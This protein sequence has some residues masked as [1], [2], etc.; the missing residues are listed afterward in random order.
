V[1]AP[2]RPVSNK[3]VIKGM[4]D[5]FA[6]GDVGVVVGALSGNVVWTEAENHPYADRNPYKGP[7]AVLSGIFARIPAEWDDFQVL[8]ERY[9]E[10][11][12]QVVVEGRYTGRYKANG[13]AIDGQFVHSWTLEGGKV[14][15]FQQYTDTAQWQQVTGPAASAGVNRVVH[16]EIGAQDPERCAKFFG[17][18]FGW[19]IM[20]WEGPQP[21][22]LATTGPMSGVGINGGILRHPD[23]AA[24]TINTIQVDSIENA[25]E[26]VE[27]A[28]GKVAMPKMAIPGVGWLAY[29]HDTEG[30]MFG[31]HVPDPAAK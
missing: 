19:Q 22:W 12:S 25:I 31:I 11:E 13:S 2:S 17:D 5:A 3:D 10:E 29:C 8:P 20:K 16:F 9:T 24:R 7:D 1:S 18:V 4:Y 14:T 26:R 28:G 15:A 23:G 27:K 30:G 6:K 21:Y